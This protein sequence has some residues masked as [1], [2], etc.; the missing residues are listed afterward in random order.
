MELLSGRRLLMISHLDEEFALEVI[1][2]LVDLARSDPN[3]KTHIL[4]LLN[5]DIERVNASKG[6]KSAGKLSTLH[7]TIKLIEGDGVLGEHTNKE[8]ADSQNVTEATMSN[9]LTGLFAKIAG[10]EGLLKE[11]HELSDLPFRLKKLD[12]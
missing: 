7:V 8:L 10:M 2:L 12:K 6:K 9:Y 1:K 3:V 11:I 5:Q 4:R